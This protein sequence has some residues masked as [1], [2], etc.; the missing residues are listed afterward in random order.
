M[1][2]WQPN[3][4]M[5]GAVP[6]SQIVRPGPGSPLY[7]H[8]RIVDVVCRCGERL[9]AVMDEGEGD[10]RLAVW[11]PPT[12]RNHRGEKLRSLCYGD[13]PADGD[14]VTFHCFEHGH[15]PVT[16]GQLGDSVERYRRTGR[17]Q[18][19]LVTIHREKAQR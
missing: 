14:E 13:L 5:L 7:H 11:A 10:E 1:S 19:L 3:R 4:A 18:R 15:G 6:E 17:R 8:A 16:G 12:A 9:G 2:E